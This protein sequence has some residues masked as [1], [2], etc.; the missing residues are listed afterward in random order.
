MVDGPI[1]AHVE[2]LIPVEIPSLRRVLVYC[3]SGIPAL[4]QL[5]ILWV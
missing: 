4:L 2:R 3:S 5:S 1:G